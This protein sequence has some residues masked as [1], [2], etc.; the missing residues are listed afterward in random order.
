MTLPGCPGALTGSTLTCTRGALRAPD[1]AFVYSADSTGLLRLD[2]TVV[3]PQDRLVV[4][5]VEFR[6]GQLGIVGLGFSPDAQL[7][8]YDLAI[9]RIVALNGDGVGVVDAYSD[10]ATILYEGDETDDLPTE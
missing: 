1:E 10:P 5:Q 7:P 9:T 2:G 3:T 8:T 6:D 4:D